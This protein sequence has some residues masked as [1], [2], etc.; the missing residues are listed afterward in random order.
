LRYL[1][2]LANEWRAEGETGEVQ[3]LLRRL[4]EIRAGTLKIAGQDFKCLL[5]QIPP[6]LNTLLGRLGLFPLFGQ[7]PAWAEVDENIR[8]Y[9]SAIRLR[10]EF[11]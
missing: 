9:A 11:F 2:T 8:F 4:Q 5:T 7:P 3:R 10:E 1:A 6:Q